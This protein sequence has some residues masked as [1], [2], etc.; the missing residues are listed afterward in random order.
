MK[1]FSRAIKSLFTAGL[2]A[3]SSL[4]FA[5]PTLNF[6]GD[7]FYDGTG[8]YGFPTDLNITG[9]L[10]GFQDLSI[11]PAPDVTTSINSG[12]TSFALFA[13]FVSE[14]SNAFTTTG[15]FGTSSVTDLLITDNLGTGGT[16]R[17]LLTGNVITMS[18][19]GPN[20]F[21]LGN[22][23]GSL[24]LDGGALLDDFGGTGALI[25]FNYNLDTIFGSG[26]FST[27]FTGVSNGS[28]EGEFV[29]VPEPLPL[30]LLSLGLIVISLARR[31]YK[32]Y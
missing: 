22:M 18:L 8:S 13:H 9:V 1:T 16:T 19:I 32:Q 28:I 29:T 7:L 21:N 17:T 2:L 10:T 11:T 20:G 23:S 5:V 12:S 4:S 15:T 3:V 6:T 24:Q 26:M 25:A 31:I 14:T 30:A 27:F